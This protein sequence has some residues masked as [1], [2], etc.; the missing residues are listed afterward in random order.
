MKF[1]ILA[2]ALSSHSAL[3]SAT[4]ARGDRNEPICQSRLYK[5]LGITA[6]ENNQLYETRVL[7]G[8]VVSSSY[9]FAENYFDVG[10][11]CEM[12]ITVY[13]AGG[14]Q[15]GVTVLDSKTRLN[16]F[17]HTVGA[18][19]DPSVCTEGKEGF[20]SGYAAFTQ[21]DGWHHSFSTTFELAANEDGSYTLKYGQE[22][23]H[24]TCQGK[25]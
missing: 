9:D 7:S 4:P 16:P 6:A 13:Q 20:V 23:N 19:E 15:A 22:A 21:P 2:L 5:M 8:T 18:V 1:L 3:A 11:P 17:N 14:P 25:F 10:T 12:K 24:V